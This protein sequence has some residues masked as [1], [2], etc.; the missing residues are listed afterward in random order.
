MANK[1][2]SVP[3]NLTQLFNGAKPSIPN[4]SGIDELQYTEGSAG[5]ALD[6]NNRPYEYAATNR[7]QEG[8]SVVY[9]N[10][11]LS[12]GSAATVM[13]LWPESLGYVQSHS[14]GHLRFDI[15]E[16]S[17]SEFVDPMFQAYMDFYL[18]DPV[19]GI[20]HL[21]ID[22]TDERAPQIQESVFDEENY[23]F[24]PAGST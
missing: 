7:V 4:K 22:F 23:S 6:I 15:R 8:E 18:A 13:N 11:Q 2:V 17:S 10:S 9:S 19:S 24:K 16:L 21:N 14:L 12:P 20:P 5:Q 3:E 1:L